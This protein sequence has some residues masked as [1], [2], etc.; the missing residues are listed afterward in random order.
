MSYTYIAYAQF[1]EPNNNKW[2]DPGSAPTVAA[3][4]GS[5]GSA[6]AGATIVHIDTGLYRC[7][8]TIATKKDIIFKVHTDDSTYPDF[9][10]LESQRHFDLWDFIADVPAS[11]WGYATR[12]LTQ[13]LTQVQDQIS[14]NAISVYRGN[15]WA[16]SLD[17]D[18]D[19]TGALLVQFAVKRTQDDDDSESLV[20]IDTDTGLVYLNGAAAGTPADGSLVIDDALNGLIT[21]NLSADATQ[22]LKEGRRSY[23]VQVTSSTNVVTEVSIGTFRIRADIVRTP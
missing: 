14:E 13:T 1:R 11:F 8:L 4:D 15:T 18:T 5:D 20:F 2:S 3:I 17:L 16:I 6:V 12:T 19:L 21:I 23:G 7:E 10:L 22:Q 9:A